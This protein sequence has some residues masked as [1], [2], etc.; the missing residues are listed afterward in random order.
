[1]TVFIGADHRGFALK[2]ALKTYLT[3]QGFSVVDRGAV[4][5]QKGDDFVDFA[6]SVAEDVAKTP[7]GRGVL[8]CGSGIGMCIAA[9]KVHGV[10]AAVGV[11]PEQ[12]AAGCRDDSINVLSLAADYTDQHVAEQ[13]VTAFL[14]TPYGSD[15]R[16]LRRLDKITALEQG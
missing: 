7:D 14:Q 16:Y 3:T 5:V 1:M 9:N 10:R 11:S 6:K 15:E 12:V 4:S 13:L 8:L 2:E